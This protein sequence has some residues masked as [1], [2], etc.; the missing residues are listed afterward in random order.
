MNLRNVTIWATAVMML[1]VLL[2]PAGILYYM[3]LSATDIIIVPLLIWPFSGTPLLASFL[4]A[5]KLK[6]T[7]ST[8]ILL[9]STLAYSVWFAIMTAPIA[10]D[11]CGCAVFVFF[12][13]G[14]L[15]LP[16]MIPAWIVVRRLNKTTP[17][18]GTAAST[19]S[20]PAL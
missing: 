13:I 17:D 7:I 11:T 2:V 9:F 3:G 12:V 8:V 16:I 5:R 4:L 15:S 6:H 20:S 14:P 19:P 1:L 18:P 10:M